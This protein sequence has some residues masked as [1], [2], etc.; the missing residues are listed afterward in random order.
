MGKV[1]KAI[2]DQLGGNEVTTESRYQYDY[3]MVLKFGG[4]VT[5]PQAYEV[6][7]ALDKTGD[8][9]T[10]IGGADGVT[11][12]DSMFT[13]G[14]PIYAWVYLHDG[15]TD[16]Y[17]QYTAI[18]P[19]IKRAAPSDQEPTPVQQSAIDQAIAALGVA[20]E[21]T[22]A[23]VET[24][25][26][27]AAEAQASAAAAAASAAEA[28]ETAENVEENVTAARAAKAA[29][30]AARDRAVQAETSANQS[31]TAAATSE[32]NAAAS[33]TAA[34]AS[35]AAALTSEENANGA[36]M[37]AYSDANRADTAADTA[38]SAKNDAVSAKNAA[39]SAKTSAETAASTATTKASEAAASATT[40]S[41]A[42]STATTKAGEAATSATNAAASA[43]SVAS[44]A[45]QITQNAEDIDALKEDLSDVESKTAYFIL[46]DFML[47]K[48]YYNDSG[49]KKDHPT[50][51]R[52]K[53]LI[54]ISKGCVLFTVPLTIDGKYPALKIEIFDTDKTHTQ[55]VTWSASF[56][57]Y[58]TG[59][60][61][62]ADG[63]FA[64]TMQIANTATTAENF[65]KSVAVA[66]LAVNMEEGM[67]YTNIL[68]LLD[69]NPIAEPF[70]INGYW[71][72]V[73]DKVILKYTN[74]RVAT[75]I[76]IP[77]KK[78]DEV[79]PMN[80][81]VLFDLGDES[82]FRS[83]YLNIPYVVPYDGYIHIIYK[84]ASGSTVI[85]SEFANTIRIDRK[86][87][88]GVAE[89]ITM[90]SLVN[91]YFDSNYKIQ[92]ANHRVVGFDGI[93]ANKG[94]H[95]R[96]NS[97]D[98]AMTFI[99]F[100]KT[101]AY[102]T[103]S[104]YMSKN[105]VNP[106]IPCGDYIVQNDDCWICGQIYL[107]SDASASLQPSACVGAY[108]V[109]H[110]TDDATKLSNGKYR[111]PL[112]PKK[113]RIIN[114]NSFKEMQDGTIINGKLWVSCDNYNGT[115]AFKIVNIETGAVE[116]TISN[117]FSHAA[118]IDYNA[119]NDML[120]IADGQNIYLYPHPTGNESAINI[121]DCT[122]LGINSTDAV[123]SSACWGEDN[124]T[125]YNAI[126][127]D[128]TKVL[129]VI[130]KIILGMNSGAYDGTYT[131]NKTY[132][133]D[134]R[135]GVDT[136]VY[137]SNIDYTQGVE[138]D[139][140]LYL[141]YGTSGHNFLVIDLDDNTGKASVVGNY[142]YH[143][144]SEDRTEKVTEPQIV[145]LNGDKIIL[146]SR[147]WNDGTS[148]LCEFGR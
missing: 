112:S 4:A 81:D 138:Y 65:D 92:N 46:R 14:S 146:G 141:G 53:E 100:S 29:A 147:N 145:A 116:A 133:L 119:N 117:D 82:G 88:K 10:Q 86:A 22:A 19:V 54:P 21:Q 62:S 107:L 1:I 79:H 72:I 49:E 34:S 55:T 84:N 83:I 48:G 26:E 76:P 69:F 64:L 71:S 41:T 67:R 90:K 102:L 35:A 9:V 58:A 31:K 20:V 132:A 15:E 7:F 80:K 43:Q 144:M 11:V 6:H 27:K 33:A 140:Y 73:D 13:S 32:A 94:D 42:A 104:G 106:Q 129:N 87:N 143:W 85:P 109:I 50:R 36:M 118:S 115:T 59:Y 63:Y 103:S 95:V 93:H 52:T 38:T 17:T 78:G 122:T 123:I 3:G 8:A 99:E 139:G 51:W 25:T 120:L 45:A 137:R 114:E 70:L 105:Y 30:E 77:V 28:A 47:E 40:A 74:S 148:L 75:T 18:I 57:Q 2:F 128:G 126:G 23:D 60:T 61:F 124:Q 130:N 24:T 113:P 127:Y 134:V 44:S 68:S 121:A 142:M 96:I 89:R 108:E 136:T 135:D 39:Q 56:N 101:G 5:L 91:G 37:S 131:V 125:V 111:F 98:F 110:M 12:P 66:R 16:G 97:T